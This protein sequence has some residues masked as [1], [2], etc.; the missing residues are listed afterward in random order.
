MALIPEAMSRTYFL[1]GGCGPMFSEYH[2]DTVA[3]TPARDVKE[4]SRVLGSEAP[5]I[6]RL[7]DS[8]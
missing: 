2:Y 4:P 7:Q 8:L 5:G 3:M 1:L 6:S